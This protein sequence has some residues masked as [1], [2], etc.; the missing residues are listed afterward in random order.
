M[1]K[2][3][4]DMF[5]SG[6]SV[7]AKRVFGGIGFVCSIAFIAIWNRDLI[8]MLLITSASLIGL[9]TVADIFKPGQ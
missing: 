8:D 4:K 1:K 7:S 3:L 9:Q 6:D 2:F 5:S